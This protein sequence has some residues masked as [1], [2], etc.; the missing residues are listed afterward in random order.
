MVT[1]SCR[2]NHIQPHKKMILPF[3][4]DS[5]EYDEYVAT[6]ESMADDADDLPDPEQ[7]DD[8][9]LDP[10]PSEYYEDYAENDGYA[11][12]PYGRDD[13]YSEHGVES[14]CGDF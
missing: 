2:L 9:H 6:M 10:D 11:G 14:S 8:T 5:A 1:S 3:P 4:A 13:D 12:D 7:L